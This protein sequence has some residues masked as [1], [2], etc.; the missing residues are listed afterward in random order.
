MRLSGKS[1]LGTA[2]PFQR[3]FP[4]QNLKTK[5]SFLCKKL[6]SKKKLGDHMKHLTLLICIIKRDP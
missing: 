3:K 6:K 4:F 1:E 2:A 5:N